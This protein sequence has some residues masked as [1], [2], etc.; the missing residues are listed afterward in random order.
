MEI[1]KSIIPN[2]NTNIKNQSKKTPN[3]ICNTVKL[4]LKLH[5]Y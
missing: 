5:S 4:F 3:T 1:L 2:M